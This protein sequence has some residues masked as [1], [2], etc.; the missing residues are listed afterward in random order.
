MEDSLLLRLTG[1]M[2]LFCI[3]DFLVE[4]KGLDFTKKDIARGAEISKAS[5]FNYWSE[6]EERGIVKV[7]R[8]FGKT[9]LYTL[10]TESL[11]TQKIL[12]L[13]AALIR[14]AMLDHQKHTV[15]KKEV[16]LAA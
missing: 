2:P 7:T 14:Q 3:L 9:R 13:E 4:N 16:A 15:K 5:L 11:L 6:L 1:K 8:K 12:E 10:N